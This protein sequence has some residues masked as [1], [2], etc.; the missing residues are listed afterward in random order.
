MFAVCVCGVHKHRN[1][2]TFTI[3]KSLC[4]IRVLFYK[5][6]LY[7]VRHCRI[8]TEPDCSSYEL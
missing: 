7:S 6:F 3:T 4:F 5:R 2:V 8:M 1:S